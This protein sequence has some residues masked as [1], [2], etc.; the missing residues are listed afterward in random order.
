MATVYSTFANDGVRHD[1]V[2][3]RRIEDASGAVVYEAPT[4]GTR[5]LDPQVARTVTDVLTGVTRGTGTRARLPGNRLLAG[6][7]GTTDNK[8]NA[9]FVG[10]TPQ[11]VAAVWMGDPGDTT[12]RALRPMTR[13]G[14]VGAVYGGTYPAMIWQRFMAT[15]MEGQPPLWFTPPDKKLWPQSRY[16]DEDGRSRSGGNKSSGRSSG[17]DEFGNTGTTRP[18]GSFPPGTSA[19]TQPPVTTPPTTPATTPPTTGE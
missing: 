15:A 3:I 6:K 12:G 2:F 8:I 11:L 9:W 16:V 1:P 4:E 10:Y 14:S 13:V 17:N 18:R 19:T 7:T 5:V